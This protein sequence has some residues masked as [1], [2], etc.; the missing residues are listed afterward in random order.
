MYLPFP[1]SLITLPVYSLT[2]FQNHVS[3]SLNCCYMHIWIF[4]HMSKP[5]LSSVL[6]V[7]CMHIF[8]SDHLVLANQCYALRWGRV[9]LPLSASHSCL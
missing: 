6:T 9:S 3:S 2:F 8:R 5:N 7:T 1:F 4:I